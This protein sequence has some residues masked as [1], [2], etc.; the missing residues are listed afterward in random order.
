MAQLRISKIIKDGAKGPVEFQFNDSSG[1][2]FQS[3]DDLIEFVND[4][5]N[6]D[7]LM[8]KKLL[9]ASAVKDGLGAS[10]HGF[11]VNFSHKDQILNKT[12]LLD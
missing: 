9:I 10:S 6:E 12:R 1:V 4:L 8:V 2:S 5:E 11:R 3:H 7:I